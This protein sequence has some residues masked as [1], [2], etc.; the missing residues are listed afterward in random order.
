MKQLTDLL[1]DATARIECKYFQ[2]ELDGG[3]PIYRERVYCYELYHQLRCLWPTECDFSLNGE[4]DK[5]AHPILRELGADYAKPDLLVHR[6]G[7]MSGNNTIIEV[8]SSRA[9]SAGIEKDL[10]T[11]A[12]FR[13]K[14]G[15]ERAVYLLFGFEAEAAAE[16]VQRVAEQLGELPPIEL[17]LHSAPGKAATP[18]RSIDGASNG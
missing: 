12:L 8:K 10:R 5:A 3:D 6:P 9:P 13:T 16:R 4:L 17:W 11:L 7:Y 2:V 18:N 1:V 15:Y 14:V